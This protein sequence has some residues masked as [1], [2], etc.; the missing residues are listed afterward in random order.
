MTLSELAAALGLWVSDEHAGRTVA[1]L[2][3]DSRH[4]QPGMLFVTRGGDAEQAMHFAK[5]ALQGGAAAWL[6]HES[7][8]AQAKL[9]VAEEAGGDVALLTTSDPIDQA[10]CGRLAEFA[11]GHPSKQLQLVGVTGTNGKTTTAFII[12]HLLESTGVKT[13]IIGTILT[14]DGSPDGPEVATL[15]T[16]GSI[17]FSRLLARMVKNGCRAA[18][19]EVSSHALDQGRVAALQFD[20]AVFTNLTRDHLD[21]HGTMANYAAAKALLFES[22]SDDATA[23]VNAD[24]A[25][26]NRMVENTAARIVETCIVNAKAGGANQNAAVGPQLSTTSNRTR[27]LAEVIYL[28]ATG[29]RIKL[30]DLDPQIEVSIPYI[31]RHN[32]S[33]TLQAIAAANAIQPVAS[34]LDELLEQCPQVPGRLEVVTLESDTAC[35]TVVVDYAHTSDALENVLNA[36]RPITHEAGKLIVVFGCGGDRDTGKRPM[37]AEIACRLADTVVITSDNPRHENPDTILSDILKGVPKALRS[38]PQH[39]ACDHAGPVIVESDRAIAIR[40]AIDHATRHDT[41]LI[42]GKGHEDYQIIGDEK[43]HFDDREEAARGLQQWVS[44]Q[45]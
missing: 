24:D 18:V 25:Y 5:A 22:L 10:F 32:V 38:K 43:Q 33:N 7:L 30:H 13:G 17:V 3:D 44:K 31:G 12:R 9:V 4:V 1:D 41:V 11:F 20:V 27:C 39:P 23:V 45:R 35:P 16:P 15:T 2:T 19:A 40:H 36:L 6:V 37:M 28:S 42:A 34:D 8:A 21:Y 26:A 29:S 14:D